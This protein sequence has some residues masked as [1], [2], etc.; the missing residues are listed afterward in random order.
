[1]VSAGTKAEASQ[2]R[3]AAPSRRNVA[4]EAELTS[5]GCITSLLTGDMR[6]QM[7]AAVPMA[8][9]PFKVPDSMAWPAA[10]RATHSPLP[11][12]DCKRFSCA[13]GGAEMRSQGIFFRKGSRECRSP[14]ELKNARNSS[15]R[16]PGVKGGTAGIAIRQAWRCLSCVPG[17]CRGVPERT[18]LQSP[19]EGR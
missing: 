10:R 8:I 18:W 6:P 9:C 12:T 2:N 14:E 15:F 16:A 17:C 19:R 11:Q 13:D 7:T 1:M 3:M 4:S 5:P